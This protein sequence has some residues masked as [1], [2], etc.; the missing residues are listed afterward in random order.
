MAY[1][2]TLSA[3][4]LCNVLKRCNPNLRF[5]CT[6]DINYRSVAIYDGDKGFATSLS[7]CG[8]LPPRT[9]RDHLG[10]IVVRGWMDAVAHLYAGHH[11]TPTRELIR[12]MGEDA[13]RHWDEMGSFI[14]PQTDERPGVIT[15]K[16]KPKKVWKGER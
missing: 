15:L 2:G 1:T 10:T 13:F 5:S 11:I 14:L 6:R 9:I 16:D 7:E 3:G 4:E 12:L 8:Q